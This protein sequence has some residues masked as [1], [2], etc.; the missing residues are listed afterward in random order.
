MVAVRFANCHAALRK[1]KNN[2]NNP[3]EYFALSDTSALVLLWLSDGFFETE[4]ARDYVRGLDKSAG[5]PLYRTGSAVWPHYGEVI[6]NRKYAIRHLAQRHRRP[7]IIIA[8]A[9][10]DAMGVELAGLL[11]GVTIFEIDRAD[12]QA[13]QKM[14]EASDKRAK[15]PFHERSQLVC[16]SA[17]LTAPEHCLAQ[18]ENAGWQAARPSLLILEGISSYLGPAQLT[19]LV[20]ALQPACIIGDILLP[21][22]GLNG[23][24]ACISNDVFGAVEA[25]CDLP[26]VTHYSGAQLADILDYALSEQWPME[27]IEK[28]RTARLHYFA[29]PFQGWIEVVV[30]AGKENPT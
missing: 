15:E 24:A 19:D 6:T 8:G 16:V 18:L 9:G 12:M 20:G 10:L 5:L 4:T 17:D 11:D 23:E 30:L 25:A 13:K 7:Q 29:P 14:I 27:R 21:D 2:K 22:E 3:S 28:R 1:N 26:P